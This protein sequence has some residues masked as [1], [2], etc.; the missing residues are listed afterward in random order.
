MR[1]DN[2]RRSFASARFSPRPA[3]S[4]RVRKY[5]WEGT[6]EY[7]VNGAGSAR[8]RASASGR[9]IDRVPE[10]RQFTVD[11][12]D[13]YELLVRPFTVAPGVIIP[14]GGYGFSDVDGRLRLRRSSVARRARC[15][16]RRGEF[17]DGDITRV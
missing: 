2:F 5:T 7:L 14:G 3:A 17:Y 15:H 11:V 13:N 1:R 4:K 6:F 10:Q 9:F 8:E 16:C 12:S